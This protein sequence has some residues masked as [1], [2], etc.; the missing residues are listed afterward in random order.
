[1]AKEDFGNKL[2]KRFN[3]FILLMAGMEVTG[4][5]ISVADKVHKLINLGLSPAEVTEILGK[6]TN[7][8]TAIT[9]SKKNKVKKKG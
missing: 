3:V 8:V 5:P 1:M 4:N 7:Y 9:H 2:L 6:N